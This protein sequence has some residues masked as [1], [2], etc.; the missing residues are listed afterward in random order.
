MAALGVPL[1][2]AAIAW[3]AFTL[4]GIFARTS[5]HHHVS[6]PFA[7]GSILL[8]VGNGNVQIRGGDTSRVDVSYTEHYGLKHP[9]V[10]GASTASG[11]SLSG[12]CPG[13]LFGQN[14]AINYVITVPKAAALQLR[15]GDGSLTLQGVGGPIVAHTGDG[16]IHGSQLSSKSVDATVGDGSVH[17]EWVT[18]PTRVTSRVGDGSVNIS[19]PRGSGPYAIQHSGSGSSNIAVATDPAA[20]S[21]MDLH[22]GT[23]SIR[24]G[25]GN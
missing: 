7:G 16:A 14:C 18:G 19:V 17:L 21:T 20:A 25:Y 1:M 3:S 23:G 10:S 9:T 4:V 5:E 6:Y 24:V 8:N 2:L 12:H 22:V 15:V 11:V 13:G